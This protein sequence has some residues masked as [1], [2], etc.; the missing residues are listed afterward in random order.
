MARGRADRRRAAV[1]G[2]A[3]A[4][5]ALLVTAGV[6]VVAAPPPAGAA[7]P[8]VQPLSIT[9]VARQC[10]SYADVMANKARNN[11]QESLRDLGAD[12][13][14]QP[15]GEVT[16]A[17]EDAGSPGC[18]PLPGWGF[19]T[20][21][22][23]TAKTAATLELSTVT[24]LIRSD[25]VT[26]PAV[27]ELDSAGLP[28]GRS[29]AGA[30]TVT[31]DA[32][33]QRAAQRSSLWV[34]GGTPAQ[35]LNGQ[36]D[37]YGFAALRCA[38]DAVNGDNVEQVSYPSGARH[39]LCYAYVVTPPPTAGTITVR[40]EIAPGSSGSGSFAF[41]G[42]LSYADR[43]ADGVGDF[44]LDAS[45]RSPGEATFV[46]GA[47]G[48]PWT[49]QE[50]DAPGWDPAGLPDCTATNPDGPATSTITVGSDQ[51]VSVTLGARDAVVCTFTNGRSVTGAQLRKETLGGTGDFRFELVGST[52]P[53][54][55]AEVTT[56]QEGVPATALDLA[57]I[58]AETYTA[59]EVLPAS[60]PA[61]SWELEQASCNGQPLTVTSTGPLRR[62]AEV[63]ASAGP[64]DCVVTNR[65]TPGGSITVAKTTEGGT[66]VSD[67]VVT[68]QGDQTTTYAGTATTS[69]AGTPAL[70][71]RGG[72][73]AGPLV[74]GLPVDPA[75]VYTVTELLPA[76]TDEGRWELVSADCGPGTG[77]VVPA[78]T[79]VD[80]TLTVAAPDPVCSFI[81][82]FIAYGTLDVVKVTTA[83]TALRPGDASLTL[84]C[85]DQTF[86]FTVPP[87]ADRAAVP[88]QRVTA[89]GTCTVTEAATGAGPGVRADTSAVLT[90][91]GAS[92]PYVLGQPF[93][94]APGQAV[95]LTV[96]NALV[97]PVPPPATADP[98]TDPGAGVPPPAADDP[99]RTGRRGGVLA[100]TG[101]TGVGDLAAL[102][103]GLLASGLALVLPVRAVRRSRAAQG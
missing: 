12:S 102:G 40:K 42:N 30:V 11:L 64:L 39:V 76:P 53:P 35:P 21:T 81:N 58:P 100:V 36:Q 33:E 97:D 54:V 90:V 99:P 7:V 55:V 47:G 96:T 85:G 27:P 66:G 37:Q 59:T 17:A 48:Q 38:R 10:A 68:P 101:A 71:T 98:P 65:F 75:S 46:R 26:Q 28:T 3:R 57:S 82:R 70:A 63:T 60:T 89:A 16:V 78:T 62:Q 20:G 87:G 2:L 23:F 43:D 77:P 49:F 61:G 51:S 45:D 88:Q 56:T 73:G 9:Y 83:D 80:V 44:A 52:D 13:T 32:A 84:V 67:F 4:L 74:D 79:S 25:V 103:A 31:L 19:S 69:A 24:G 1:A 50:A 14:Y 8:A 95:V 91:D 94:V 34:Q 72:S 92:Q 29:V 93:A 6:A 22:G 15:G 18:A 5:V 86:P 41:T